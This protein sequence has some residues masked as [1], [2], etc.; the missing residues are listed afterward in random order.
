MIVDLAGKVLSRTR[1]ARWMH[2]PTSWGADCLN[3]RLAGYQEE[4]LDALPVQRRV[5]LRGPHGLGKS[6]LG[7][8]L[9]NWFA[10]T[11][12]LAGVDWKIITT[13]SAWRHLEVYLWPEIHKWANRIDFETLGRSP[14]NPRTEL[15]DQIGRAHV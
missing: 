5:A 3:A 6:F 2:S 9:V 11:R 4:V 1:L 14:F 8:F 7:A 10:T 12:D 13:A 15:L